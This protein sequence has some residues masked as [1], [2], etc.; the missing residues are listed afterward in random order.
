MPPA[1]TTYLPPTLQRPAPP[2][3]ILTPTCQLSRLFSKNKQTLTYGCYA[4][5]T[6]TVAWA[7]AHPSA[8]LY[9]YSHFLRLTAFPST[10]LL[11]SSNRHQPTHKRSFSGL[12]AG[13]LP[14]S[15]CRELLPSGSSSGLGDYGSE[16]L[17]T[18]SG[19]CTSC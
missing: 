10:H 17:T 4:E 15:S 19:L 9:H 11:Q 8:S 14:V 18:S 16:C 1:L 2:T 13:E 6:A 7:L 5:L 3:S 12:D